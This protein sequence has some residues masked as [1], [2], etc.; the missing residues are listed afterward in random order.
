MPSLPL[1]LTGLFFVAILAIAAWG[2]KKTQNVNDFLLGGGVLGPWILAISYGAAYFSAVVF[3]GFAGQYGWLSSYKALWVGVANAIF[4]GLVAW[5][6]LGRRTRAMT[7]RLN[8]STTP[9]FFATRYGSNGMKIAGAVIIFLFM[10]PYSASVFAGLTYLFTEVFGISLVAALTSVVV[11]T[12]LYIVFGGYKAAA[13]ID[14]LQGIIMF[15]GATAMVW[16]VA[17]HFA[18]EFGGYGAAF[19]KA[20]ELYRLRLEGA[21]GELQVAPV[22]PISPLLFWS[23]VFMTSIAPWGLPQMVHKYYAIKDESQIVKGA[24]VCFVFAML[25]GCAA[26]LT[27]AFSHLLPADVLAKTLND[28]GQVDPNKLVPT[29]LVECLPQWFLAI[30]L[31]LVLSASM[32]TLCSLALVSSAA[33][34]VDL[35]KG[36]IAPNAS[37]KTHL[38]IFRVCCAVFVIVSYFI[39]LFNPS[40]IV[41]LMSLSWGAVAGAF[42]APYMYGLYWR[43]TTKAGAIAG[44]VAGLLVANALYWG[45]FVVEGPGAAKKYS[46]LVATVSMLVPFVV[47]PLVSLATKPLSPER[48]AKAFG[49]EA[50]STDEKTDAVA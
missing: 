3:I 2:M 28:A 43:R 19:A 50:D 38:T 49:D 36:F 47:V 34:G 14:F 26:Y 25:V 13:R 11:V 44:M 18:K 39:A 31:L 27:G 10:L 4:G 41:A 17:N 24:V 40:W 23:V 6:V 33:I 48:V 30:I 22:D 12:G 1:L 20:S 15:V 5:L 7:R 29:M 9:E 45:L 46:P 35:V 42:L 16:F 37:E 32:S 8:A 21:A